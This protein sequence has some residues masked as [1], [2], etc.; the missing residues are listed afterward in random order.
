MIFW[1]TMKLAVTPPPPALKQRLVIVATRMPLW[2]SF[3]SKRI[4]SPVFCLV[5]QRKTRTL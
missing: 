2:E 3:L 5:R 4:L 1:V